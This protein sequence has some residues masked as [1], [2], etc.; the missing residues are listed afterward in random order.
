MARKADQV[1]RKTFDHIGPEDTVM[2]KTLASFSVALMALA[3]VS[4]ASAAT[5]KK[6]AIRSES[7]TTS[8]NNGQMILGMD[9]D[10]NVRAALIRLGDPGSISGAGD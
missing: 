10:V 6:H 3:S 5:G 4:A 2:K 8:V 1:N 7:V 9:P